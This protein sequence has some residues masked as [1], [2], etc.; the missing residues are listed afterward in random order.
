MNASR[1]SKHRLMPFAVALVALMPGAAL[2]QPEADDLA[3]AARLLEDVRDN[4]FSFD[5]PAFYWFCRF[6]ASGKADVALAGKE[7]PESLPWTLLLERPSDFRGKPVV[8]EGTL[9]AIRAFDVTNREGLGRLYQCELSETGTR[10]LGAVIC[11]QEPLAVPL[12]SRVRVKGYFIKVRAFQ[13]SAGETGAG[14]LIV[15]KNLHLLSP[16]ATGIP[17]GGPAASLDRWLIPGI[18][19]L[20]I[21]WLW[22]R[23]AATRRTAARDSH[24][25]GRSGTRVPARRDTDDDFA[26]LP[27]DNAPPRASENP[28]DS[29][30]SNSTPS[31]S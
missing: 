22:L 16:P 20:A 21:L 5:D 10:A 13:T 27:P 9:Q 26:W 29:K 17:G 23:R 4:V 2:A 28:V 12:R 11:T 14:P 8:I 3:H 15:A 19:L 18:A 30:S 25:A 1:L 31:A 24:L 6:V 7:S